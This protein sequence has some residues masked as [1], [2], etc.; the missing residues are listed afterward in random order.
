VAVVAS[1]D[2]YDRLCLKHPAMG[3]FNRKRQDPDAGADSTTGEP[4]KEKG[5][6]KRPAS[7]FVSI[8]T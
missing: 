3:L 1:H 2:L 5:A 4:K 6:W 8:G 7:A